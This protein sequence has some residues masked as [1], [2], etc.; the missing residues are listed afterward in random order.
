MYTMNQ[1]AQNRILIIKAPTLRCSGSC[2]GLSGAISKC[3]DKAADY[4][5]KEGRN[6]GPTE[7]A[8]RDFCSP[9]PD[10]QTLNSGSSEN[11]KPR[12]AD[13]AWDCAWSRL[14]FGFRTSCRR[15]PARSCLRHQASNPPPNSHPWPRPR[16]S[17]L[18]ATHTAFMST[19][20]QPIY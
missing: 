9:M 13:L 6:F 11:A 4:L 15:K 17:K 3:R 18:P 16:N 8:Q 2:F 12:F 1:E 20:D 7:G 14:S 5:G 10:S 19:N